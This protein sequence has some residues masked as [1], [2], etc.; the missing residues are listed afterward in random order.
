MQGIRP[1]PP[2]KPTLETP[3]E[4]NPRGPRKSRVSKANHGLRTVANSPLPRFG[5]G[6]GKERDPVFLRFWKSVAVGAGLARAGA[7]RRE[8]IAGL[9]VGFFLEGWRRVWLW[10]G[11]GGGDYVQGDAACKRGIEISCVFDVGVVSLIFV[12]RGVW[13]S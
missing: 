10:L 7:G 1:S 12:E 8:G 11:G 13:V 3:G 5:S 6:V 9:A 4:S 2:Q